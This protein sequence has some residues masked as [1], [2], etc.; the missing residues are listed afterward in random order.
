MG[1]GIRRAR[2]ILGL[3]LALAL[4]L[5]V[6][7]CSDAGNG[8]VT[9]TI[10]SRDDPE[11]E[12][13]GEIY[14]QALQA[15]GYKVK[16]DFDFSFALGEPLPALQEGQISGYPEHVNT[17]L[18]S[19]GLYPNELPSDPEGAYEK[20]KAGLEKEELT[21]FPPTP[22]ALANAFTV[23]KKTAEERGLTTIS[24]LQGQAEEI[25]VNGPFDCRI[26]I[27][28]LGGL[29]RYRLVF[30]AFDPID[31]ALRHPTEPILRYKSLEK[32]TTDASMLPST[33]GRL[34]A[35]KDKFVA[36]EDDR[37]L[38]P[39]GNVIF[40]TSR[41]V[42]EEAGSD[43]EETIVEVQKGLTLP[44]MQE[45]DAEVEFE[46]KDPAEVAARYLKS[47]GYTG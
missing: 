3:L 43:F 9:L 47:G 33:D 39:A 46:K 23:L 15:S 32:H 11:G 27:E 24:D 45:L 1:I 36:L 17:V 16:K 7:A 25:T 18:S 30:K 14:A 41:K 20:A 6:T 34:A 10:G 5:A 29:D 2:P 42:A 40:V 44:V 13:L 26:S 35:E 31:P 4:S 22:F 37:H 12:V 28:C 21:A 8:D 38:L 19:V